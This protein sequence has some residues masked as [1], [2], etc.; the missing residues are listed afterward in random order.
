[1]RRILW[2]IGVG[3]GGFLVGGKMN[4]LEGSAIGFVYGASLGFG[5]SS[6]FDQTHATKWVVVY[7]GLTMALV[8]P[9]FG[10]IIGAMFLSDLSVVNGIIAGGIGAAVGM[11][12]GFLIGVI[13]LKRLR[14]HDHASTGARTPTTTTR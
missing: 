3:I 1:M 7:W 11:L 5:I 10:L 4:G 6:I 14:A 13:Q 9:Y 12:F 2:T 8:G